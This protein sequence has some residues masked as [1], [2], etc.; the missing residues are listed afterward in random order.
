MNPDATQSEP[1]PKAAKSSLKRLF[2]WPF[3]YIDNLKSESTRRVAHTLIATTIVA[4]VCFVWSNRASLLDVSKTVLEML[5]SPINVSLKSGIWTIPSGVWT[6]ALALLSVLWILYFIYWIRSRH[7]KI[8]ELESVIK[9]AQLPHDK[10]VFERMNA[11][12]DKSRFKDICRCIRDYQFYDEEQLDK[13]LA[14]DRFGDLIENQFL[15]EAL[16]E[17]FS[18]FHK[19]LIEMNTTTA[20]VFFSVGKRY[21]LYPELKHNPQD[22]EKRRIYDDALE[23]VLKVVSNVLDSYDWFRREVKSRLYL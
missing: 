18:V 7:K 10:Q 13:V 14:L 1:A 4:I 23:E 16:Q 3:N 9:T 5:Q 21:C 12:A 2:D 17:R 15:D 22:S 6:T 8:K 20:R 19:A 11:I